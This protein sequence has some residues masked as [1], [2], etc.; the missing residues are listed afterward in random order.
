MVTEPVAE[1]EPRVSIVR[2][3]TPRIFFCMG[4][5]K[6]FGVMAAP[7]EI[8][9]RRCHGINIAQLASKEGNI[10][11][12]A[13]YVVEDKVEEY[14]CRGCKKLLC[15]GIDLR[16]RLT[17]VCPRCKEANGILGEPTMLSI[18][19]EG[20][21][22]ME[23]LLRVMEQRWDAYGKKAA[24]KRAEVAAGL[25]FDVFYRDK[26]RCRYCGISVDD[27]A[28]LHADHVTP[29]S[30]GGADDID[31]LVTACLNCNLGKSDKTL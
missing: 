11:V 3:P 16:G 2:D 13:E 20:G 23:Q 27:G 14:R 5:G 8:T 31:N 15:T 4:C 28:V 26:F 30:K 7:F 29:R 17:V 22:S 9:C 19:K 25:R 24:R 12:E 10:V 6:R 18:A 21:L 1:E